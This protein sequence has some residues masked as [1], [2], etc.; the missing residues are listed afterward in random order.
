[1]VRVFV[2]FEGFRVRVVNLG[3]RVFDFFLGFVLAF[4]LR[5]CVGFMLMILGY[6]V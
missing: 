4:F 5:V 3:F 2:C 1:M 6:K